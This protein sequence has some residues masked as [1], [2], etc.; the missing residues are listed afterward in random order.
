M[1]IFFSIE[2]FLLGYLAALILHAFL[3]DD[4]KDKFY[5]K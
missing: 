5:K 2:S 3:W 1:I 4:F